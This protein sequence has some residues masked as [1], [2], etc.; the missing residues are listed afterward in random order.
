MLQGR[1]QAADKRLVRFGKMGDMIAEISDAMGGHEPAEQQ[2]FRPALVLKPAREAVAR[3]DVGAGEMSRF[4]A[5]AD[6]FRGQFA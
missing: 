3:G 2:L 6:K 1:L 4:G 5:R